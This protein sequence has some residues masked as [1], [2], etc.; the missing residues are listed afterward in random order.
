V[1]APQNLQTH[2]QTAP[3]ELESNI[4]THKIFH[5][6]NKILG[7]P[8]SSVGVATGYELDGPGIKSRWKARFSAPFQTGPEA[9]PASCPMGTGSFPGGK[10]RPG[11]DSDPSP[12]S[13][14]RWS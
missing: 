12:P 7:V 13:S 6:H 1:K 4:K 11:R 5:K 2:L 9:H 8:G 14:S 10:E 3:L